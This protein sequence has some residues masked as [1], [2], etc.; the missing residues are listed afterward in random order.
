MVGP[1]ET[2][3][4]VLSA[5][6]VLREHAQRAAAVAGVELDVLARPAEARAR[7]AQAPV[8]LVGDDVLREVEALGLR[9]R[10]EVLVLTRSYDADVPWRAALAVGTETVLTVPQD[11]AVLAQRLTERG[12]GPGDRAVV[13]GVL[14]G[15][16]GAGAS[17]LAA[18]LAVGA[19]RRGLDPVLV[20]V[21]PDGG[22][23][24]L[25]LGA[26]ELAGAR[27]RDFA[28]VAGRLAPDTLRA[29]LPQAHEVHLLSADRQGG[30][31]PSDAAAAVLES[32]VL[33]FGLVVLDL[34]RGHRTL[35][36]VV[37]PVCHEV[38]VVVPTT[39]RAA[40]ASQ[41][42]VDA[43]RGLAPMRLVARH[44]PGSGVHPDELA[45]WL[46]LELAAEIAHDP[47]LTAALDRG[48]PPGLVPR[49]RLARVCADLLAQ[50]RPGR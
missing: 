33:G 31:F 35:V 12:R 49:S 17:V 18:A 4:L 48:D 42:R 2:R 23:C 6:P 46:G 27:W 1:V 19:G 50:L 28:D 14:G 39:V 10:A 32:A 40:S 34:P 41:V 11:D 45:S 7:W 47:R 22:G 15:C 29:A 44:Q 38:L 24:D 25:L 8:V 16:G 43:L 20:D 5:D 9:R 13:L 37:A 3:P 36:E 26:E 30:G 21:D